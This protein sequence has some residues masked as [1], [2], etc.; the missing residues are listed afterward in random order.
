MLKS[1]FA[2]LAVLHGLVHIWFV[3]LIQE[4]VP[5]E[6]QMGWTG[7]SWLLGKIVGGPALKGVATILYTSAA[8]AFVVGGVGVLIQGGWWRPVLTA[9]ALVSMT[10]ILLFWDGRGQYI[11]QKG[12][13][14]FLLDAAILVLLVVFN[15]PA[16][17]L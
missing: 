12:L 13:I 17:R 5:F 15:W 2:I 3:V 16:A 6:P 9:S 1:L 4:W 8:A 14:G 11:V 7:E 10:A